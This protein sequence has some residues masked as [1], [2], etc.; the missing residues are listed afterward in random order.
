MFD[1][2]TTSG[3]YSIGMEG[4][5]GQFILRSPSV[6]NFFQ[7]DFSPVGEFKDRNLSA[8]EKQ[9][10]NEGSIVKLLNEMGHL[11][12]YSFGTAW[13]EIQQLAETCYGCGY[14]NTDEEVDVLV[15]GGAEALVDHL[16]F[17]LLSGVEY[18]PQIK[19]ILLEFIN[20]QYPLINDPEF[21]N[22]DNLEGDE[23]ALAIKAAREGVVGTLINLIIA[24]PQF[25]MQR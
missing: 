2:Q 21:G 20:E 10:I 12:Q 11:A 19:S 14:L 8:P 17:Y 4:R 25:A 15:E 6:F 13:I 18:D 24:T 9:I 23:R 16:L 3:I 1:V 5:F 22:W 7:P